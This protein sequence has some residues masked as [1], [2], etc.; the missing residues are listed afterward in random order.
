MPEAVELLRRHDIAFVVADSAGRWPL[1]EAVT[2]SFVYVRLH[3]AEEL[4][5]SGY[6]AEALDAWAGKAAGWLD[7]GLDVYVYFDNDV[8]VRAPYDAMGLA[9]RL[10]VAS[11]S[12]GPPPPAGAG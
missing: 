9:Q 3:G 11:S 12:G 7:R 8:K 2:S 1:V 5:T 10:G 4:Y 6:T